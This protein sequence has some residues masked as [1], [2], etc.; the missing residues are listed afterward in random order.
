MSTVAAA[1]LFD[2]FEASASVRLRRGALGRLGP[3]EAV[4]DLFAGAGGWDQGAL[5]AGLPCHAAINHDAVAIDTHET[6]HPACLHFRGDAWRVRPATVMRAVR[7]RFGLGRLGVL[8]ASAACTT[9]SP[10][11]GAAP[12]SPRV[13]MLG[14]CIARWMRDERPRVVLIENVPA[15]RDWG[16]TIEKRDGQGRIVRDAQGRTIRVQCPRRKG[17]AYRRWL[18]YIVGQ[19]GYRV[20][21][22]VLEAADFGSASRRRRLYLVC[23]RDEG[24]IAWPEPT[25]IGRHRAA[26]EVIDWTD[27]GTSVLA[28]PRPLKPKTIDRICEGVRRY[29]L[30]RAEPFTLPVTYGGDG[31]RVRS[32][33]EPLATQ[34]TRQDQA[35]VTPVVAVCA[36]GAGANGDERWGRGALPVDGPLNAIHAGGNNFGVAVPVL[37][38][39]NFGQSQ[40]GPVDAPARTVVAGG[41]HAGLVTPLIAPQNTGVFGAGADK[42]GPTI[43]TKGHQAMVAPVLMNNTTHHTGGAIDAPAPTVTTG[44]QGGLVAPVLAEYFGNGGAH[45]A[46]ESVRCITCVDRRALVAPVLALAPDADRARA[47]GAMLRSRLGAA[48]RLNDQGMALCTVG[49]VEYVIVD[50][51]FRM[52][53]PPELAA[54][55]G[56]PPEYRWPKVKRHA[57]RLIGNAVHVEVARALVAAALPGERS[58]RAGRRRAA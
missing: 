3:D 16:P 33:G 50:I 10:A 1:G 14:W 27:L 51:L 17:S 43:T 31:W 22:R 35:V 57:V 49:G 18:R 45:A 5:A 39:L 2:V 38:Y 26:A 28:R 15:W 56:F 37:A 44:G 36:H 11:R 32:A 55:M 53:Q 40:S 41:L 29:V 47:I 46:D 30:E 13:H 21:E 52:L 23:R 54:A 4:V 42:P 48:V 8:L 19:L 12:I 7:E 20:E 24:A 34:T 25:H 9:H 6:N 58:R